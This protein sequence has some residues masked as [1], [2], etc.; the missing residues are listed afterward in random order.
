VATNTWQAFLCDRIVTLGYYVWLRSN[1]FCAGRFTPQEIE[2]QEDYARWCR[3]T[4]LGFERYLCS[5]D[6][7]NL[8]YNFVFSG[9]HSEFSKMPSSKNQFNTE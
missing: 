5:W 1:T 7:P 9:F 8:L 2:E 4:V 3:D 6:V